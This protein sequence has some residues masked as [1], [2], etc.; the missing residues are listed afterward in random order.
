M[1]VGCTARGGN[2]GGAGLSWDAETA[3]AEADQVGTD[4]AA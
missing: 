1:G 3:G 2:V 4:A